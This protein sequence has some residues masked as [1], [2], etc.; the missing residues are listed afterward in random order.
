MVSLVRSG[1]RSLLV[2]TSDRQR[3]IE[4]LTQNYGAVLV[5]QE[6]VA[7]KSEENHTILFI[8][9]Y[10]DDNHES[11]EK[12]DALL[13][14]ED[15]LSI[16]CKLSP[17]ISDGTI[18]SIRPGHHILIMRTAGDMHKV[19][20][21]VQEDLGGTIGDYFDC[22]EN[23]FENTTVI[24]LTEKPL[25]KPLTQ[26]DFHPQFI[27]LNE[28]YFNVKQVLR[29]H[30]IK[31]L[32]LGVDSREW[33]TLEIRIY[34]S[35]GAYELHY[36]RLLTVL[37]SLQL[38]FVVGESW[39]KDQPRALLF[40][41]VYSI[42]FLTF[43]SPAEIKKILFGLEYLDDGRRIVDYDLHQKGK[44]LQWSSLF[45][46]EKNMDKKA[47]A[48][49]TRAELLS[50]LSEATRRELLDLEREILKTRY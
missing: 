40:I 33:T 9:R 29:R 2:T 3:L 27:R 46:W 17:V 18:T 4:I 48:A 8:I 15:S 13:I 42:R 20:A 35:F 12:I 26:E 1:P 31:Y 10:L 6:T 22:I 49:E 45:K 19:L 44:K 16:V 11:Y 47:I 14:Y 39:V 50:R 28:D 32:N 36:K 24:G 25:Y 43:K 38:G 41:D 34:D 37:D 5:D 7:E 30:S 23:S 21:K